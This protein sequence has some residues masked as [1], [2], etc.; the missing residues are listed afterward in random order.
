MDADNKSPIKALRSEGIGCEDIAARLGRHPS[1]VW[2]EMD[3]GRG[4]GGVYRAEAA[5]AAAQRRARRPRVPKLEADSRLAARVRR[6]MKRGWSPH[7]VS[8]DLAA[9]GTRVCAE[10]ICRAAYSGCALGAKAWKLLPRRR[11]RRARC[12]RGDKAS[13]LGEVRPLSHRPRA[14]ADRSES[15]HWE[16]DLIVGAANQTAAATLVERVSRHTLVVPLPHGCKAP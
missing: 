3:R 4:P 7:S 9:E 13:P 2:R 5:Q 6:R 16:G 14:A 10:T 8:A 15:G 1:T 12:R 11:C